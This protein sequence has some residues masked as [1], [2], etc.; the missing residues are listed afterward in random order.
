VNRE[1]VIRGAE[2]LGIPLETAIAE[3]ITALKSDAERLG[4][5]GTTHSVSP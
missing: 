5:M 2:Q 3:V 4:L 1:D